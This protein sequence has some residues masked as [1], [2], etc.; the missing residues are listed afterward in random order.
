MFVFLRDAAQGTDSFDLV[1]EAIWFGCTKLLDPE[2][3]Q[4][5]VTFVLKLEG[6]W[7]QNRVVG[8]QK[9]DQSHI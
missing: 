2:Q 5:F 7:K 1:I 8:K 9:P 3:L 4:D 6:K